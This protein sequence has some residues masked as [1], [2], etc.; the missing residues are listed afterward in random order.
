MLSSMTPIYI[1][2]SDKPL[3]LPR[4]RST[5]C[6]CPVAQSTALQLCLDEVAKESLTDATDK[7]KLVMIS[8][9]LPQIQEALQKAI[10]EM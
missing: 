9:A 3:T 8:K 7:Q 4:N 6:R 1:N 5:R 2:P 10:A